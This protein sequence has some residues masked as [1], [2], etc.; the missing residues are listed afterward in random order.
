MDSDSSR[1]TWAFPD[2]GWSTVGQATGDDESSRRALDRLLRRYIRPLQCHLISSMGIRPDRADDLVQGFVA[3]RILTGNLL[4]L[5]DRQRGKFRTL[6]TTALEN[7]TKSAMRHD[8]ALK[9]Q[10]ADVPV[11]SLPD[12]DV[13]PASAKTPPEAFEVAWARE[14]LAEA[15]RRTES[16][17]REAGRQEIWLAFE[18]RALKP[19]LHGEDPPSC[20]ELA[21]RL[22]LGSPQKVSNAVVTCGRALRQ[23]IRSVIREYVADDSAVDDEVRELREILGRGRQYTL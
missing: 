10:P 14:V 11:T 12:S 6:L 22:G 5:A 18:L 23:S 20:A 15:L 7:Y 8:E 4:V 2:T 21:S 16:H 17:Y 13:I 19:A 3:D 9:R 1:A